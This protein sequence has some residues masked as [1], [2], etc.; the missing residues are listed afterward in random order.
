MPAYPTYVDDLGYAQQ[1]T[2]APGEIDSA[3]TCVFALKVADR[4]VLQATCDKFLNAPAKGAVTYTLLGEVIF[5]SFM[6]ADR[7]TCGSEQI[8][9]QPDHECAFWVP[10]VARGPGDALDRLVF[11]MPYVVISI[12]QG[13]VTGREIWGF[14]KEVGMVAVPDL[15]D[16]QLKFETLAMVFDPLDNATEGRIEPL[17]TVEGP[18]HE[19]GIARLWDDLESAVR[20]FDEVWT[21]GGG[22]LSTDGGLI[23]TTLEHLIGGDVPLVNLKQ[24]RDAAD[25]TLACYQ[26]LV[27]G[28]CKIRKLYAAGLFPPG[29]TATIP[30]WAS[31]RI[32]EH[33]GLPTSGAIPVEFG[34]WVKMDFAAL[35]GRE[36]WKAGPGAEPPLPPGCLSLPFPFRKW[37]SGS[38]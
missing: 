32:A 36:I 29:Y 2:R 14:R 4:A 25:S 9:W 16:A 18:G 22:T 17:I 33:L 38:R 19:G 35:P 1:C 10:L 28:P 24:F 23:L 12:A 31:H 7:L 15:A 37:F 13:M 30:S 26:A 3:L 21:G 8:G 5:V 11:W 20:G 34:S 27:E 6:H